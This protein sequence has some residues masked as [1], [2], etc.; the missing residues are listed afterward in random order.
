MVAWAEVIEEGQL[1]EAWRGGDRAAGE[2]LIERHYD[3]VARF[4]ASKAGGQ[5]DDLTQRTF[6]LCAGS[7]AGFRAEGSFRGFLF[8]I[9]RNVLYE[10]IRGRLRDARIEPDF[11][12]S[13]L[14]DLAPGVATLAGRRVEQRILGQALHSIPLESQLVLELHYW[15]ELSVEE[16]GEALGVPPG[17]VKSRLHRAR[18]LLRE[19]MRRV[20]STPEEAESASLLLAQWAAGVRARVP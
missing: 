8:G 18:A 5:A 12:A 20:P 10:H 6:L 13:S 15:E 19:A 4:F 1:V 17:T 11:T 14:A 7:I 9:A 16:L 2:A 3:A